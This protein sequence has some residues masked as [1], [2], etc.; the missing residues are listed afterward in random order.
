MPLAPENQTH[1]NAAEGYLTL[2]LFLEA[3][4]ELARVPL[5]AEPRAE[6][7]MVKVHL[8]QATKRWLD[9]QAAA[10]ELVSLEPF[11]PQWVLA[12]AYATRRAKSIAT[13]RVILA[14]ALNQHPANPMILYNLACYDCQLG[15][16]RSAKK[17]LKTAFGLDP[18]LKN[19]ALDDEDLEP[20][21]TS[22]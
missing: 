5:D 22:L 9:L 16:L 8:Y 20:L 7:L 6:V 1:L 3:E 17:F 19:P 15:D 18:D 2:G 13:A 14:A 4:A 21:W 12:L 10:M 11:D